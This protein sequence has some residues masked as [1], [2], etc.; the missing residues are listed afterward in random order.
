MKVQELSKLNQAKLQLWSHKVNK[1]WDDV[2]RINQPEAQYFAIGEILHIFG[3]EII[4]RVYFALI[5][6]YEPFHGTPYLCA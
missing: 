4:W 3:R 5:C 6:F 2:A 1:V